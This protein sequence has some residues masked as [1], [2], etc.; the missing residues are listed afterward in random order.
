MAQ[1]FLR[2]ILLCLFRRRNIHIQLDSFYNKR[3]DFFFLMCAPM[4]L[5]YISSAGRIY[6]PSHCYPSDN[7][8]AVEIPKTLSWCELLSSLQKKPLC[9]SSGTNIPFSVWQYFALIS[10][11]LEV[12][13]EMVT[14][15]NSEAFA[16]IIG[17]LGFGLHHQVN[18]LSFGWMKLRLWLLSMMSTW[19]YLSLFLRVVWLCFSSFFIAEW[20]LDVHFLVWRYSS[21]YQCYFGNMMMI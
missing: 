8:G 4:F 20:C 16:H 17:T 15:L 5:P 7:A 1:T 3:E 10:H 14:Q 6:R 2:Y 12:Y 18:P 21:N 19:T 11:M 13:P 9:F